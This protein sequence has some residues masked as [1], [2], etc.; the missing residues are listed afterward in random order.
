VVG[1]ILR[2]GYKESPIQAATAAGRGARQGSKGG[3]LPRRF[4][5]VGKLPDNHLFVRKLQNTIFKNKKNSIL[6]K[7]LGKINTFTSE[8][9]V[10]VGKL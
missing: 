9:A 4:L 3:R 7:K 10:S 2:Q 5:A 8:F 6:K 1:Y